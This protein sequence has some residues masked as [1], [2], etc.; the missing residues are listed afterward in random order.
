M[1]GDVGR[2]QAPSGDP[3]VS[4]AGQISLGTRD[5]NLANQVG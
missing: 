5:I 3:S 1:A 4:G 2:S